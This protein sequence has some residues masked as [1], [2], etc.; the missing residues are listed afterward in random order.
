VAEGAA[1]LG[2]SE[3]LHAT[4]EWIEDQADAPDEEQAEED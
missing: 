2:A 4:A 1:D 3:T